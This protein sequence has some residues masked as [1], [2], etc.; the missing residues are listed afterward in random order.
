MKKK[1]QITFF[2]YFTNLLSTEYHLGWLASLRLHLN[3]K[4]EIQGHLNQSHLISMSNEI[5]SV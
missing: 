3:E 1:F 4:G 5:E 2:Y